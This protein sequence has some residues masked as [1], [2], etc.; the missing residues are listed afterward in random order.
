MNINGETM[1]FKNDKGY[2]TTIS[3]K[4]ADGSYENM[5]I[6]VNLTNGIEV[7]NKTKINVKN[8]FLGFYK[9]KDGLPKVKM[10]ISEIEKPLNLPF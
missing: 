9:T 3:N 7:P 4:N 8:G 6:S 2:Y 1:I 10:V 5:L